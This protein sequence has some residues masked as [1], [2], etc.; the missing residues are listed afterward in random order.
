MSRAKTASKAHA[1]RKRP[2]QPPPASTRR[3]P[4]GQKLIASLS[5]LLA[6]ATI[7][8]YS[9]VLGHSFLVYDD[10]GYVT[11]NPHLRPGLAWSTLTW[12]FTTNQEGH[13]HPLTWLS[14]AL[15]YQLFA[16]NPVGHHFDSILIHALNA[17]VLFLLL[18]WA[19]KRV[20]P[21]LL[22]AAL[23]A[24]HPL[25][26]E[27]VAWVAERK[28][29]LSTLFFLLAIAAYV[30]YARAPD[31]RRYVLV[32]ALFAAA[33]M[34]KPSVIILPFVLLLLDYW[35]L[36]RMRFSESESA[37]DLGVT[38]VPFSKLLLEKVPLLLLSAASAL[39]TMQAQRSP[40]ALG[41]LH[42]LP[43]S[44]RIENAVVCYGLYLWKTIWP[45][46][47][48]ALYPYPANSFPVWQVILSALL[49]AGVTVLVLVFRRKRYLLIGWLWF[50][51]T[52]IP[53]IGLVPIVGAA[54]MA[55][56]YVYVPLIGI[57]VM[58]A[59]SLDDW[60][61]AK[62]IPPAW[63]AWQAIPVLCVLLVLSL[64][65]LRQMSYWDSDYDLWLH[66]VEVTPL[67]PV[68]QNGLA[69]ALM[70]PDLLMTKK[71]R[72]NFD[73][74]DK[75]M[76]EARLHFERALDLHQSL[77]QQDPTALSD[78]A[79]S[80]N[81]LG[82]L[83]R[84]QNRIDEGLQH[85]E[86]ALKIYREL[87]RQNPNKYLADLASTLSSLAD[88]EAF[89][90]R[91]DQAR[92]HYEEALKIERGLALHNPAYIRDIVI[93]QYNL[94]NF[95][96]P[97]QRMAEAR[98]DYEEAL[99]S[100]QRLAPQNLGSYL[101][102]FA[103]TL[104]QIG[105]W[106]ASKNRM[107]EAR[108]RY[109]EALTLVRQL[110]QQDPKYL[111]DMFTALNNLGNLALGQKRMDDAR[112]LYEEALNIQS[113]L[114][115][116]NP[117]KSRPGMAM[118]MANLG[119]LDWHQNRQD[120]A[121]QHF[122]QALK[123]YRPLAQ[124]DSATYLPEMITT[125]NNL[126]NLD[127]QQNRINEAR[128][129]FEQAL[130]AYRWLAQQDPGKYLP[131]VAWGLQNLGNLDREQNR[132]EESQAHYQEALSLFRQLAQRDGKYVGDVATTEASLK[133]LR[134]KTPPR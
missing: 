78:M 30:R 117:E 45:A 84:L 6:A 85:R 26:V 116:Q 69:D 90:N 124:Q 71:N 21:S 15:D 52:S 25:N 83:D 53:I 22:V 56:R 87:A 48:T 112:R 81:N 100:Y 72:E 113:Q 76:Q 89:R 9:P 57:F 77:M 7:A 79:Q 103:A 123:I 101:P 10:Q 36:N 104:N 74:P 18:T 92:Q 11:A 16:L 122:E 47:L 120:E 12:A 119:N 5:V 41:G 110:A 107:D 93:T 43:L 88:L 106:D 4:T 27:S 70:N 13:W 2:N 131:Y 14:H 127:R 8:L 133:E 102:V 75:R 34:A 82:N 67:N 49:L 37:L 73:T 3:F 125:L 32:A 86:A 109:E 108:E 19:T 39:I 59:W 55:D 114:E 134:K 62:K 97:Q 61:Q 111:P 98:Q 63:Y 50:L 66:A 29:V 38:G 128:E 99:K 130:E 51:G 46:R 129:C 132:S 65:S 31:W 64:V 23:F 28:N 44:I 91:M 58:I 95:D 80:L 24:V 54:V 94:E 42:Q 33:L 17:V 35:P 96:P 121:R 60:A 118:A 1:D 126:G 40:V 105:L 115:Q 20:G 68:A